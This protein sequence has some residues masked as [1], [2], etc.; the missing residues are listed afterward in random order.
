MPKLADKEKLDRDSTACQHHQ[1][2][3]LVCID[4]MSL[5]T[6]SGGYQSVLVITDHFTPY[7]QVVPT[8][9]QAERTTAETLFST[10]IAHYRFPKRRHADQGVNLKRKG[11]R[12]LCQIAGIDKSRASPYHPMGN[13]LTERFNRTLLSVLG[14]L[15]PECKQ[16]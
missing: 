11:M 6:S 9:N 1:P 13:G 8:R 10:F 4:Y 15:A 16:S 14:T 12:E 5:E 7:T 3:K 2:L